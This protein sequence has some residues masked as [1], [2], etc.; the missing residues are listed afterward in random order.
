MIRTGKLSRQAFDFILQHLVY[1]SQIGT[2]GYGISHLYFELSILQI[3]PQPISVLT[4]FYGCRFLNDLV[5]GQSLS[6]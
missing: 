6:L 2:G 3:I 4:A 1:V 5:S